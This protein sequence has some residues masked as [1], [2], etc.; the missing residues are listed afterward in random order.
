MPRNITVTFADGSTHVYQ[1]AP[2]NVTPEQVSQRASRDFGKPVK[3]LDGGRGRALATPTRAVAPARA[4]PRYKQSPQEAG[5]IVLNA[6]NG[7]INRMRREGR[8]P[9]EQRRA[10]VRFDADP[11]IQDIRQYAGMP[12]VVTRQEAIKQ[13]GRR[14]AEKGPRTYGA[15]LTAGISRSLFGLPERAA[16]GWLYYTGQAGDLNYDE[17]LTAV[18]SKTDA[19]MEMAPKTAFAG[20]V[21]G[22]LAG[23]GF[24]GGVAKR[25]GAKLAAS[26]RPIVARSGNVLEGLVTMRKGQKLRNTGKVM[27]SGAAGGAAQAAGEGSDVGEGALYGAAAPLVIGGVIKAGGLGKKLV[28]QA[29]RPF[30]SSTSKAMREVVSEAPEAVA[31]RHAALSDQVGENVPVV[32]ALND[33]DFRAVAQQVVKRSPEAEAIAKGHTG[34]YLR[35]FMNRMLGHVNRAGRTG[36]AQ[37]TSIGELAQLRRNTADDLMHPIK[38][39]TVD[40]TQLPLDDLERQ[41]TREIGGRIKGLAPRM[42]DAF[43]DIDPNELD[44]LGLDASDLNAARKLMSDWG[45]G[46]PVQATVKEMDSLRRA[47]DAA[48]KSSQASNPANAMAYRNA[49]KTIRDFVESEVPEYGQ[50]VDTYAAQSRMMEGFETSAAGKRISD[51]ADDQLR[52]NLQ[53]PEGRVGMKAG[54]LFRQREAVSA[55]PT[56]AIAAAR[57]YA[58]EGNLTRPAS[59]DPGAAQP[60][61]ITENL[62]EQAAAGLARASQGE[63]QV[64]GRMLDTEKVH[65]MARSEDGALSPEEIAYGAF[66]GNALASV[67]ARFLASLVA[68][69]PHGFNPKVAENIAE[70]LYSQDPAASAKALAALNK[71]GFTERMVRGLM[72]DANASIAAGALAGGEGV[73]DDGTPSGEP[74]SVQDDLT[75]MDENGEPENPEE[76]MQEPGEEGQYDAIL[77]QVYETENPELLDLIDRVSGQESGGQ[78]FDQNGNPLESSAG[79]IG[80]MQVMPETA[81]EAARLAGLPWDENAYYH[82]PAYN[83]LLGIA[84]LSEMLRRY[85]GDVDKALAA[86]NAGPGRLDDSLAGGGDWLATMPA[87][88]QD[89]VARIS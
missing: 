15:A 83:K 54:E 41:V 68:K 59:L 89:Y 50:M 7:L 55:K 34:Q 19:Q 63:T 45:F 84:Y 3:S 80:V 21:G 46:K 49:A 14:A 62:G 40:L 13:A 70:M 52:K 23:G 24:V 74:V 2:D 30:S 88:T 72:E 73:P 75:G 16:A 64:L 66:L 33:G 77:Q 8:T 10:L 12:K 48:G 27:V 44:K 58:A 18:R 61:M 20:Q 51:I 57:N 67:K 42:K 17:T 82:D 5:Q 31:A 36:D 4:A 39:R 56:S 76:D 6:R 85:D 53:T 86:Y 87:E 71:I 65:A 69:L 35:T 22:S 9:E 79:A 81:P 32:A 29:T 38:D 60:G 78:Q 47:L 37:I 26:S 11:R 43:N 25:A 1:N 28:R